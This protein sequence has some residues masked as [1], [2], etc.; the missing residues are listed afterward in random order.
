MAMTITTMM[1]LQLTLSDDD[2]SATDDNNL[3]GNCEESITKTDEIGNSKEVL[4]VDTIP[5]QKRGPG[6]PR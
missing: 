3:D 4:K 5:E 1:K 2:Y 6:R